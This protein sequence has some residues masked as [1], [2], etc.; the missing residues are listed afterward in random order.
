MKWLALFAACFASSIISLG[1]VA[2]MDMTLPP[3]KVPCVVTYH[4]TKKIFNVDKHG[5]YRIPPKEVQKTLALVGT[6]VHRAGNLEC[7]V[8]VTAT[9][10]PVKV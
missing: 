4:Y 8:D 6:G 1:V 2:W 3:A 9:Y 5:H 7:D 10:N